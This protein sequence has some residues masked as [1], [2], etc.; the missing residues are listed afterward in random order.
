MPRGE[1]SKSTSARVRDATEPVGPQHRETLYEHMYRVYP[2]VESER[3]IVDHQLT[4]LFRK[5]SGW[6]GRIW[7]GPDGEI[8]AHVIARKVRPLVRIAREEF[9]GVAPPVLR[10]HVT[11]ETLYVDSVG[12]EYRYRRRGLAG[13]I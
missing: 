5:R 10:K 12:V 13:I 6:Q 11:P 2:S 8:A 3:Q 1:R 4:E 7:R 9:G